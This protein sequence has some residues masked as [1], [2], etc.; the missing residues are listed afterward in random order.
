MKVRSLP[1]IVLGLVLIPSFTSFADT[2]PPASPIEG[3]A[4]TTVAEP[5]AAP[6]ISPVGVS[7][8][9]FFAGPG[10]SQ[11]IGVPPSLATGQAADSG[12]NFWNLV[13]VKW[14]FS[15][16]LAL[17][18]QF[19]NQLVFVSDAARSQTGSSFLEFRHQ[20]QRFGVSGKLLSGDEWNLRG[21]V[22]TDLP[23]R[24][25]LGQIP[26]DRTLILN[27][28]MWATFDY[29]PKS[30]RWSLF[31]LLTPRMWFYRDRGAVA[32]QDLAACTDQDTGALICDPLT[33]KPLMI[34]SANPSI[35]Y[36]VSPKVGVRLGTTI[37]Y[38]QTAAGG[39]LQ[40]DIMPM[41]LGVTYD[42]MP[43]LSIYT[44]L[45]T[46]TP[47]DDGVRRDLYGMTK[48]VA[49]YNTASINVWLSGTIF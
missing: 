24:A 10:I 9:S 47:L 31:A 27:P 7:Y 23:V 2:A 49:W 28:G 34:L 29:A 1:A 11:S 30:S 18:V 48:P 4:S 21:A 6:K 46:T 20:G 5:V 37:S 22:N 3:A 12:L 16:R 15:E 17:D 8:D 14:R 36:Q 25:I 38:M 19:R 45:Q 43:A 39:G 40:R 32:S 44:Y 33:N 26:S 35:N 41:E 13:S 42:L